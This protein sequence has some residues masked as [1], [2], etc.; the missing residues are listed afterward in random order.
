MPLETPYTSQ[1]M[2]QL[3]HV[4][5]YYVHKLFTV[6]VDTRMYMYEC[7]PKYMYVHVHLQV[8]QWE[9]QVPVDTV[10]TYMYV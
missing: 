3:L 4:P 5:A 7:S 9:L 6:H 8:E 10:C 2:V 1:A